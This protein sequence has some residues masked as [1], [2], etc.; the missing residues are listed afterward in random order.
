[1]DAFETIFGICVTV[2]LV[3]CYAS[4]FEYFLNFFFFNINP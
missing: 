1:M 4:F 2:V 3:C